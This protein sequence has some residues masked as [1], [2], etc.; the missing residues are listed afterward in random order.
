MLPEETEY[1]INITFQFIYKER[2]TKQEYRHFIMTLHV[3][4]LNLDWHKYVAFD[5][6]SIYSTSYLDAETEGKIINVAI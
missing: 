3:M 5:M 6:I 2:D 1:N 4:L